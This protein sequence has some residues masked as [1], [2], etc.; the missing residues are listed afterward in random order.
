[1]N[2]YSSANA[3]HLWYCSNM[4]IS[5]N[6]V[7]NHRDGIYLEFVSELDK[8]ASGKVRK[9]VIRDA[10]VTKSTWDREAVGYLPARD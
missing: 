2:E 1:V 3:I 10:G 6:K 4:L 9:Q 7:H 5:N 8:T